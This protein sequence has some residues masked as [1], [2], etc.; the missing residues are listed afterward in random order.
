VNIGNLAKV[1]EHYMVTSVTDRARYMEICSI[2]ILTSDIL[3]Q[4]KIRQSIKEL[5]IGELFIHNSTSH[6][7]KEK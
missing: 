2:C 5:L 7:K 4:E 1:R 3:V 6:D